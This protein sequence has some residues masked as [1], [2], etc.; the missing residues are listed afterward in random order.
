MMHMQ[1]TAAYA[2]CM[3]VCARD[4]HMVYRVHAKVHVA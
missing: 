2:S 4:L 1:D 3:S